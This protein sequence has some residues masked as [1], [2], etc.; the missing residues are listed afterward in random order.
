MQDVLPNT[1]NK[2]VKIRNRFIKNISISYLYF[3]AK[4]NKKIKYLKLDLK[5]WF[6]L[7]PEN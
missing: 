2:L 6:N 1:Q 4:L 5:R 7:V 3:Y